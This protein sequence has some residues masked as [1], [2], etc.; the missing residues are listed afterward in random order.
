MLWAFPSL[1]GGLAFLILAVTAA[2]NPPTTK[3][4]APAN[5]KKLPIDSDWP[6]EEA[7]KTEL[8]GSRKRGSQK[9]WTSPDYTY[10]GNTVTNVQAAVRFA[11][12]HGVRLSVLNSGHDFIGR[13]EQLHWLTAS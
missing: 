1:A 9:K 7:W 8:K 3:L 12:K 4:P 2:E 6:S 11:A 10:D 5:C 13:Y